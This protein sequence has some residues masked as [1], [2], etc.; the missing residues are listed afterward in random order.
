[1]KTITRTVKAVSF[2]VMILGILSIASVLFR[3][4]IQ[5]A[6]TGHWSNTIT[7]TNQ[8]D[9][10][11]IGAKEVQ[12]PFDHHNGHGNDF[13]IFEWQGKFLASE[14][15]VIEKQEC[16]WLLKRKY[17]FEGQQNEQTIYLLNPYNLFIY[18]IGRFAM[19]F[20]FSLLWLAFIGWILFR[21]FKYPEPPSNQNFS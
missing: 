5:A 13:L 16:F 18:F 2:A 8:L 6:V 20:I 12:L 15:P 9:L 3:G 1:M 14:N 21:L 17:Q 19:L 4:G 11:S 7:F 10:K